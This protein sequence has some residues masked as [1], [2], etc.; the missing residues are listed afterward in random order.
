[1]EDEKLT[2]GAAD[3]GRADAQNSQSSSDAHSE[4][5][6]TKP[7]WV[8]NLGKRFYGDSRLDAY[9]DKTMADA[10]AELLDRPERKAV[11]DKYPDDVFNGTGLTAEEAERIDGHYRE[12]IPKWMTKEMGKDELEKSERAKSAVRKIDPNGADGILADEWAMRNPR[13]ISLLAALDKELGEDW[14]KAPE[15]REKAEPR[16]SFISSFTE[17]M[18]KGMKR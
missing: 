4:I 8:K 2:E 1:M 9:K 18:L 12:A 3:S 17:D 11:P 5:P 7:A 15:E 16:P 13:V 6:D 10:F 14:R